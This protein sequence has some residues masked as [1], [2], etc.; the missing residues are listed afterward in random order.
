[1]FD[2]VATALVSLASDDGPLCKNP[3]KARP[4]SHSFVRVDGSID[5]Y[6][7]FTYFVIRSQAVLRQG[8]KGERNLLLVVRREQWSYCLVDHD[9]EMLEALE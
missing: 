1:M 4:S 9:N 3:C 7:L 5:R 2:S 6:C 8:R